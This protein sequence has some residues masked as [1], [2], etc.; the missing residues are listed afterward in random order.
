MKNQP[1][2]HLYANF[3]NW[4]LLLLGILF[5]GLILF[6]ESQLPNIGFGMVLGL[7]IGK[8]VNWFRPKEDED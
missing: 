7:Y 1:G 8:K 6:T 5:G 4:S 3:P 2:D